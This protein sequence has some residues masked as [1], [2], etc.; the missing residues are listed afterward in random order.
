MFANIIKCLLLPMKKNIRY[1]NKSL[2]NK[3]ELL[4]VRKVKSKIVEYGPALLIIVIVIEL[5][6]HLLIPLILYYLG[7]NVNDIFYF[8]VPTAIIFCFH[9]LSAPIIFLIYVVFFK[10]KHRNA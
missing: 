2:G 8:L 4:I 6:K 10:K 1:I 7:K 3:F 9:F 5:T